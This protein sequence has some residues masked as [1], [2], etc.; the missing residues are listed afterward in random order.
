VLA[1][2]KPVKV[3]MRVERQRGWDTQKQSERA[4]MGGA[5]GATTYGHHKP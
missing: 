3:K 1:D 4:M 2:P 5:V